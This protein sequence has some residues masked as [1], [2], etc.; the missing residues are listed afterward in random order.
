MLLL[1]RLVEAQLRVVTTHLQR[2]S[3]RGWGACVV[4]GKPHYLCQR[5]VVSNMNQPGHCIHMPSWKLR[6]Q[7]VQRQRIMH[8]QQLGALPA[9]T[10]LASAGILL[11]LC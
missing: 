8:P 7:E 10:M 5:M 2:N 1:L 3:C 11:G 6:A 4:G 9:H